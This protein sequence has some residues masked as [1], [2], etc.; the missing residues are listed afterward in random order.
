MGLGLRRTI[1]NSP[2]NHG[3]IPAVFTCFCSYGIRS[4]IKKV[5]SR[6]FLRPIYASQ[7]GR[8]LRFSEDRGH[9]FSRIRPLVRS[10]SQM[11]KW[12]GGSECLKKTGFI[13]SYF[14]DGPAHQG[15]EYLISRSPARSPEARPGSCRESTGKHADIFSLGMKSNFK[16][17]MITSMIF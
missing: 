6:Q 13:P 17:L 7:T 5:F 15:G 1:S 16:T 8:N 12:G 3:N 4:P 11:A 14:G 10:R 9:R 2:R